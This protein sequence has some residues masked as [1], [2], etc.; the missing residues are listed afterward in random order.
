L[1]LAPALIAHRAIGSVTQYL[2]L[3]ARS[4]LM[5]RIGHWRATEDLLGGLKLAYP[6]VFFNHGK[7]VC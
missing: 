4:L 3:W 5:G 7:Q 6:T 2:C 1:V